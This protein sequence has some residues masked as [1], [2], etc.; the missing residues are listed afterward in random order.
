MSQELRP[1]QTEPLNKGL[2]L[3]SGNTLRLFAL[4]W[5][6]WKSFHNNA[7]S[8]HGTGHDFMRRMLEKVL[9]FSAIK[10]C[11]VLQQL[12]QNFNMGD[13][14]IWELLLVHLKARWPGSRGEAGHKMATVRF[15]TTEL[16]VCGCFP[17]TECLSASAPPRGTCPCLASS[18]NCVFFGTARP[19]HP[20]WLCRSP[21]PVMRAENKVL[22]K[23]KNWTWWMG[24]SAEHCEV[25]SLSSVNRSGCYLEDVSNEPFQYLQH[26]FHSTFC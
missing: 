8:V 25:C 15:S 1:D 14:Q 18:L 6:S 9:S 13:G 5:S 21:T 12:G 7:L 19:V 2:T 10:S 20:S 3:E 16:V 23:Q 22:S 4:D 17:L 24:N 11:Q 26:H